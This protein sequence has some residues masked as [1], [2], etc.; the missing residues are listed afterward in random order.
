MIHSDIMLP[1]HASL[2]SAFTAL[3]APTGTA[4]VYGEFELENGSKALPLKYHLIAQVYR[5]T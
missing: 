4:V 3:E 2:H 1:M 5:F